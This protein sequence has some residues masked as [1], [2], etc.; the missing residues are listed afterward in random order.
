[1]FE[2]PDSPS[3][4]VDDD[5]LYDRVCGCLNSILDGEVNVVTRLAVTASVLFYMLQ[6]VNWVGFY[7]FR[8]S[9]LVLGPFHGKPGCLRIPLGKGVCG[10]VAL[11]RKPLVVDDVALFP[12][13]IACDASSRSE[14]VIP[15][16]SSDGI[17]R[18][19]LDVDSPVPSRFSEVD[20]GRLSEVCGIVQA[21]C[22]WE[23]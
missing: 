5:V 16:V 9:E 4:W 7:V 23:V 2:I 20:A 3:K 15:L 17:L 10:T 11:N 13:H 21:N 1:M 22:I 12:G 8:D 6:D 19:V 14:V 18:A